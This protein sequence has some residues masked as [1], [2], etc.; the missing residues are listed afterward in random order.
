MAGG[1]P[2]WRNV[3]DDLTRRIDADE[4]PIGAK[5]PS[6]AQL[7]THYGV[8][9]NAVLQA[10]GTLQDKGLLEGHGGSGNFVAARSGGIPLTNE[11]LTQI[12][13]DLERRLAEVERKTGSQDG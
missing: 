10:V 11:Q 3:A 7:E 6:I 1:K 8:S 4:W 13:Q 5:I 12:V 9:R 2:K